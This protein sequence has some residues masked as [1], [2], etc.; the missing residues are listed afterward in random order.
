MSSES[1]HVVDGN[2]V[3]QAEE[4]ARRRIWEE[5]LEMI[6]VHNLESSLGL[7]SYELAMNH[8]GDMVRRLAGALPVQNYLQWLV[9]Q[10]IRVLTRQ[11]S[12]VAADLQQELTGPTRFSRPVDFWGAKEDAVGHHRAL[13]P[14][15][16][17]LQL[18]LEEQI[19][20]AFSG[21]E[22]PRP[23]VRGQNAGEERETKPQVNWCATLLTWRTRRNVS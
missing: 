9:T 11:T 21:L 12:R 15:Q 10:E 19:S 22:G 20:A 23:G 4:L 7:H 8:L 1:C 17:F 18:C 5:N 13:W 2:A 6:N 14:G 16:D 3:F